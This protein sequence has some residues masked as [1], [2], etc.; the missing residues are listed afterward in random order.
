MDVVIGVGIFLAILSLIEGGYFLARNR[1]NPEIKKVKSRLKILSQMDYVNGDIDIVRKK[2]LSEVPWFNRILLSI[3]WTHKLN[4]LIEQAGIKRPLGFFILLSLLLAMGGGLVMAFVKS[5]FTVPVAVLLGLTPFF[6]IRQKKKG[7][8]SKFQRQLPETMDLI[9]RALKAGHAFTGGLRLV[10]EELGDPIGTEFERTLNEINYG[11][12][13][14]EALI[15]LADRVDCPDLKFFVM[16]VIIQRETGG[17]LAEILENIAHL[18]RERFKLQGRIK[19][20][21]AEGKLSAIILVAIPFVVAF[22]LSI[23]NPGY[24][25]TLVEDPIGRVFIVFAVLMMVMGI[26]MMKNMIAIKV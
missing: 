24:I 18:I 16:S 10:V 23:I 2:L 5:P 9:A 13:A 12:A 25:N 4:H 22:A 11:V 20:L 15:N 8:M 3:N 1:W 21:S 17:N 7:R 6:Y 14:G 19:V 26:L